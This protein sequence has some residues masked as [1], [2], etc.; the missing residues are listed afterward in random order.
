V[1]EVSLP[2]LPNYLELDGVN[3]T[4]TSSSSPVDVPVTGIT[5]NWIVAF[6]FRNVQG[7]EDRKTK[8]ELCTQWAPPADS[9][10]GCQAS[11]TL[12]QTLFMVGDLDVNLSPK[13]TSTNNPGAPQFKD[14]LVEPDRIGKRFD[15]FCGGDSDVHSRCNHIHEVT[16]YPQ[17][18]SGTTYPTYHCVDGACDIGMYHQ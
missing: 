16:I 4:P 17:T 13:H 10:S 11:G 2:Y 3:T 18:I 15:I 5:T 6:S 12:Q 8:F 1:W 14:D 7:G 9:S